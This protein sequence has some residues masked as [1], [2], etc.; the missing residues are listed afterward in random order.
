MA[1]KSGQWECVLS[2]CWCHVP[3]WLLTCSSNFIKWSVASDIID[4]LVL[5]QMCCLAANLLTTALV[6]LLYNV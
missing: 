5:S 2:L 6:L 4:D 1:N 3:Q